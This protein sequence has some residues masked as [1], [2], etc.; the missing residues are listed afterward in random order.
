MVKRFILR[1]VLQDLKN[2]NYFVRV[3]ELLRPG[4]I[5][6][7]NMIHLIFSVNVL[8]GGNIASIH[9]YWTEDSL[10]RFWDGD[11]SQH[12]EYVCYEYWE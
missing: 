10:H 8:S 3:K 5:M 1:T 11:H 2:V 9:E 6:R 7:I 12:P 4:F